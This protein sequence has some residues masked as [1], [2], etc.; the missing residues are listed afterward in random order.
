MVRSQ[1]AHFIKLS[2]FFQIKTTSIAEIAFS[3]GEHRSRTGFVLRRTNYLSDSVPDLRDLL[4]RLTAGEKYNKK[5]KKQ[6]TPCG[7]LLVR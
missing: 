2:I 4:S 6:N 5:Q 7:G 3:G 1:R